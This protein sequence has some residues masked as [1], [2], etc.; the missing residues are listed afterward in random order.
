[1]QDAYSQTAAL[2]SGSVQTSDEAFNAFISQFSSIVKASNPSK[3]LL[4]LFNASNVNTAKYLDQ[5]I[6]A[7][8]KQAIKPSDELLTNL[9]TIRSTIKDYRKEQVRQQKEQEISAVGPAMNLRP[10]LIT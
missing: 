6:R 2:R 8:I 10:R 4:A 1:M 3:T 7:V 9:Q 5:F